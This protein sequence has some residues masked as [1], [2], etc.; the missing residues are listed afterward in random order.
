MK[1]PSVH[2][3]AEFEKSYN[4]TKKIQKY[5]YEKLK[6]FLKSDTGHTVGEDLKHELSPFK[7]FP[8]GHVD[9]RCLFIL[10]KHCKGKILDKN[11]CSFCDKI[12]HT[13]DD[14]VLFYMSSHDRAYA[15]GK[16]IIKKFKRSTT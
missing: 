15:N 11:K 10:C 1:C 14:A 5:Q 12:E 4:P 16:R 2:N 8:R 3:H 13:M 9:I 6:R 7:S